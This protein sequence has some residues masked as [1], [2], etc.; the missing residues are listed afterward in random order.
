VTQNITLN[1][2]KKDRKEAPEEIQKR[3]K[4]IKP[5]LLAYRANACNPQPD[6]KTMRVGVRVRDRIRIRVED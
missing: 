1:F 5:Y 3:K 2:R 4:I 6:V